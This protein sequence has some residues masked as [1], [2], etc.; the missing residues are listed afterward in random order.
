[1]TLVIDTSVWI[2]YFNVAAHSDL[3]EEALRDGR[4]YL[5]PIVAAELTSGEL[6]KVNLKKLSSFLRDLPLCV[7]PLDHWIRVGVLRQKLR[8]LGESISTPDAHVAQCAIDLDAPLLSRDSVFER[9]E[10]L[11]GLRRLTI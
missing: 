4:V 9:I 3:V 7:T 10:K 1:M 8:R 5:P 6:S 2:D 11:S